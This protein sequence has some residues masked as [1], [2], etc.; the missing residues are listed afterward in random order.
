[1]AEKVKIHTRQ[2]RSTW[3]CFATIG[4]DYSFK[5]ETV[6]EAQEKMR[7]KLRE[8]Q[9]DFPTLE[10]TQPVTYKED[11]IKKAAIGYAKNRVDNI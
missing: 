10:F 2:I 6:I 5:G 1:M 7:D 8:L 9:I 4:Y 3:F 11:R